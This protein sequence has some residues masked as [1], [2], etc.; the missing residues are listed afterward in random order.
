LLLMVALSVLPLVNLFATS[1]YDV[2]WARGQA[3]WT[4]RGLA[5]YAALPSDALFRAALLNTLLFAVGA[6]G[7]Q[8]VL[9]FLLALLCSRVT[10]G[11][12]CIGP[13]SS[14]RSSS[15]ELSSV[16]SGS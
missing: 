2:T 8:M 14:C 16:R 4:L 7:G 12:A 13:C 9:G 6:V 3:I 11:Q 1:F 5:N 10:R 15:L